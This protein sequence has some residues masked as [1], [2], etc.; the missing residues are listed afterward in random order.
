MQPDD[1]TIEPEETS[2]EAA[3]ESASPESPDG[4]KRPTLVYAAL[5]AGAAVLVILLLIVWLSSRD[6]DGGD[7]PLCLDIAVND[8]SEEI[9]SGGV[10]RIDVLVDGDQPLDGLTAI[11]LRM[12][13]GECRRLPEGADSR[14]QLYQ[15]LGVTSLYNEEGENR[16]DVNWMRQDV[17]AA[18]LATSTPIPSETPVP[19]ET[20]VPTETPAPTQTATPRMSPEPASPQPSPFATG[21]SAVT[22]VPAATTAASPVPPGSP[23]AASPVPSPEPPS[24]E[25]S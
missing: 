5:A 8:A 13:N 10:E 19:T 6:D 7:Q 1:A 11:Q 23:T 2:D 12:E 17:P 4:P 18:L 21:T 14:D 3:S 22:A 20:S 9:L 16:V 15:I 25:P 24:P